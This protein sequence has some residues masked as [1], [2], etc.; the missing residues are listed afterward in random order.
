MIR[1]SN[2]NMAIFCSEDGSLLSFLDLPRG[3]RWSI[4]EKT[5]A[6]GVIEATRDIDPVLLPI[7]PHEAIRVGENVLTV[8]Y[9]AGSYLLKYEY[10][11]LDDYIEIRMPASI[12]EEI[13]NVTFP[14]AFVPAGESFKLVMPIMQGMLWDGRGKAHESFAPETNHGGFSMPMIGY[15][16]QTGGLLFTAET[17]DDVL[18][19]HGKEEGSERYWATNVQLSS[20]GSMRYERI[21]RLYFTDAS[22]VSMA[23]TYRRKKIEQGR[24]KSW[25]EKI[26]ERPGL[27]R[28]F[29]ALMCFIGYCQDN[30]LDYAAECA[31]LKAYGFDR[32]LVY[33]VR[34]NNFQTNYL[35]GGLPP[36]QLD[37][38]EVEK[39]KQLGYDI[40]PWSWVNEALDTGSEE[41]RKRYRKRKD[42]SI[43]PMWKI[44][45]Q[46][47]YMTC[48]TTLEQYQLEAMRTT[49][50]D[51]TWDHFDVIACDALRECYALDHPN[52]LGY[53]TSR[54]EDRVWIRKLLLAAQSNGGAVSSET[55]ND[56]YSM[57]YDIG[58]VKAWPMFA[59]W[60]YWPIPLNMLVYHDSMI[61]SWWEVH[62]YNNHEHGHGVKVHKFYEK[63]GN[64]PHL[65]AAMDALYGSPPDVFPFGAMYTWTGKE[66][67]TR[68]YR[69]RFEDPEVQLALKVALPVAELHR[70]I[71]KLEMT[72]HRFLSDD[73]NVQET[74]FSDGTRIIAN[75]SGELRT[76]EGQEALPAE[77]WRMASS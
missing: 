63:G 66:K 57:E 35:M 70:K 56:A 32:A 65:M 39:I 55:F 36:L 49:I 48:N 24:F 50:A 53:P 75:F 17:Q 21:G 73:G 72:N 45:D 68:A 13:K 6:Y 43:I 42:G 41:I 29:G 8:Y 76:V 46:Q 60:P 40:A 58:S 69:F 31:K 7:Q 2:E 54:T 19:W 27:E 33:P 22:Y 38:A 14:G 26:A 4:D 10:R 67:E 64:R 47:W 62:N 30:E 37:H 18:W 44:D 77:S 34:F 1:I 3:T 23:K 61:H 28:L 12:S 59:Y 74:A 5:L 52:H 71:G 16:A 51:M 25:D 20:L 9:K 15:L 11:L